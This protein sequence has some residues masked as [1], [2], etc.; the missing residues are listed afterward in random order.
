MLG[1]KKKSTVLLTFAVFLH[2]SSSIVCFISLTTLIVAGIE[3]TT[4]KIFM[5][6]ALLVTLRLSTSPTFAAGINYLGEICS[7]LGRIQRF[8]ELEES[9]YLENSY[10]SSKRPRSKTRSFLDLTD[11]DLGK[12]LSSED[13]SKISSDIRSGRTLH[14]YEAALPK[15][16]VSGEAK[17][18]PD[19]HVTFENVTCHWS[20]GSK[21][22][23]LKDIG[24]KISTKELVL[25]NGPAGCG[26]SSLLS[27]ILGELPPTEGKVS[28]HGKIAYVPQTPWIFTE[29]LR[30]NI[31]FGQAYNPFR[32]QAVLNSCNLQ[33]EADKL[34]EGDMT[35]IGSHGVELSG[36]LKARISLAR[37]AY[38]D[39]DIYLLDDPLFEVDG[40]V[41]EQVNELVN[42]LVNFLIKEY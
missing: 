22:S 37:A 17:A 12:Y 6:M 41:A 26:K 21:V 10:S 5:T 29:T 18:D 19:T 1:V 35:V 20:S 32:Y 15:A 25:I 8:L 39:A 14:Q 27:A 34:P 16:H 7:T 23:A 36:D 2:T 11:A 33:K 4:Y 3:V 24:M 31:L 30:E 42:K 13:V 38:S 9:V 40:R 28:S